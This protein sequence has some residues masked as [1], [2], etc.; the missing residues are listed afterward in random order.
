MILT[1]LNCRDLGDK[2]ENLA[3]VLKLLDL[4]GQG[5]NLTLGRIKQFEIFFRS[6]PWRSRCFEECGSLAR[7][8]RKSNIAQR[9]AFGT[10]RRANTA[11]A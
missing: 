10:S 8:G 11:V 2:P 6:V 1:L 5:L 4:G 9:A 3:T 7:G